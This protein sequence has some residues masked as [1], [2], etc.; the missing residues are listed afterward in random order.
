MANKIMRQ[1]FL[2][3]LASLALSTC[4]NAQNAGVLNL[5]RDGKAS[6]VIALANDAIPA[7][8]TAAE[9]LQKYLLKITGATFPILSE[10]EVKASAPQILV[11]AGA[12]VKVLLPTQDWQS[13][14]RDGIVIKTAGNK[15]ILA[16]GRPRGTLY[17]VF[18]FLEDVADCRWWTPTENTIPHKSTFSIAPQNVVYVPPFNYCEHYTTE[19]KDPVFATIMREN[20]HYQTQTAEWGGHYNILG[21]VHTFSQLLPPATYFKAH[22]EW[23]SDPDNGYKPCTAASKMPAPQATQL[24]LSDPAVLDELTRQAL[25]WIKKNPDAGYISISQNDNV[26]GYCRDEDAVNLIKEEGSPAAPLIEFVNKVAARINQQYPD[27]QVETLAYYY[28]EEPPKT[29]RPAKNV[30][31]RL[32]PITADFGHALNSKWNEKTR[33]NIVAWAKISHQLFLWNYVTN[34]RGTILPH[35]NFAGLADDLRFFSQHKVTGVFEQGDAYTNGVG[36]FPQLRTWLL[37]KLMWNPKLDQNQL[38]DEFLQGYYGAAAPYLRRYID[39]VQQSFLRQNRTLSTFNSD[40]FFVTVD[41]ANQ[42]LRLFDQAKNAVRDDKVLLQR[43][44]RESISIRLARLYQFQ[45]LQREAL[46]Q[47]KTLQGNPDPQLAM[48][49]LIAEAESFGVKNYQEGISFASKIPWLLNINPSKI[50]LPEFAQKY[51]AQ[52]VIDVQAGEF[53]LFGRTSGSSKSGSGELSNWEED[54]KAAGGKVA[55]IIGQTNQWAIQLPLGRFIE[56][57]NSDHWHIYAYAKIKINAGETPKPNALRSGV[58]DAIGRKAVSDRSIPT[59]QFTDDEYQ[60]IDL[61]EYPLNGGMFIWFA[62]LNDPGIEKIYI[63]RVI[64]IRQR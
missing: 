58:Y 24:N 27:F 23:Y 7:E 25:A 29:I 62:P 15:L 39:A 1:L 56:G 32:A 38:I 51:A 41:L 33:D 60:L 10:T 17:A 44:E 55:T 26:D 9:Q 4:A 59:R 35:P 48:Q 43:V 34:F 42:S 30:I 6:Y 21:F 40:F 12:R 45:S 49:Q 63:N 20:G 50:P 61:G 57:N 2:V 11:G 16:G 22:P 13:L 19:V 37:G 5:A 53:S 8:K 36:D 14:G 54:S 52:D 28:S 46:E 3:L 64:L 18:Q 31:I 47:G